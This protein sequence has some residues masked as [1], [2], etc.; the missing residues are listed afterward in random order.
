VVGL[1]S[2]TTC[3]FFP[4][5]AWVLKK[6][7][8]VTSVVTYSSIAQLGEIQ[9]TLVLFVLARPWHTLL[10]ARDFNLHSMTCGLQ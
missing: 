9:L 1:Y 6:L 4:E 3:S 8:V 2:G 7:A 10:T 5:A